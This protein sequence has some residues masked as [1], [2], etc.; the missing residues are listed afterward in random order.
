MS[1]AFSLLLLI[2]AVVIGNLLAA[3]IRLIPAA[4]W[5][6]A[7]GLLFSLL[8]WFHNFEMVPEV[9]LFVIISMLM[10]NE[11]QHTNVRKLVQN[12]G[13]TLSMS[14]WLSLATIVVVGL[15]THLFLPALS[16]PLAFVLGAIITPTDSVAVTSITSDLKVP[17]PVMETLETESLFNDA[18]GL[19]VF[20]LCIAAITTGYFSVTHAVANFIYVFGG[21]ILLGGI[22]G[23][24]LIMIRLWMIRQRLN[25]P[26]IIIPYKLLIPFII[27]VTAEL[28]GVSGI[29]AVVAA[30]IVHGWQQNLLKLSSS[31]LQIT[32]NSAWELVTSILNG[33][34]FV[35]LGISFPEVWHQLQEHSV[36]NLA[37]LVGLGLVLYVVMLVV[38]FLWVRLRF[39]KI[40]HQRKKNRFTDSALIAV[41]GV[42]GTIT[43]AMA[44]S[45]PLTLNHRPFSD[46][47]DLIFV[48]AVVIVLSLLVPTIVL[49]LTLPAKEEPVTLAELD[50]AKSETIN[51]AITLVQQQPTTNT[52]IAVIETLNSQRAEPVRSDPKKVNALMDQTRQ[53]DHD[54]IQQMLADGEIS[55]Q[56]ADTYN[57]MA[58]MMYRR[59]DQSFWQVTKDWWDRLIPFT[60]IHREHRRRKKAYLNQPASARKTDRKEWI[61]NMRRIEAKP[62]AVISDFLTNLPD[63]FNHPEIMA[64]RSFYDQ[65]HRAWNRTRD[66]QS[67]QNQLLTSAFQEEYSYI[68][69]RVQDGGF[70]KALGTKLFDEIANDQMLYIQQSSAMADAQ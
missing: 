33:I 66:E 36:H 29:L 39:V 27:Y 63:A 60:K 57:Q 40:P 11:G 19:V 25:G 69:N 42:H 62:Y 43:L 1:L 53:I 9:F 55:V 18:S 15:I 41:N 68:Q 37:L 45:L 49:K 20:N 4:F 47:T 48:S 8:P 22:L 5:D 44:F 3:K 14:V 24:F 13:A 38:R 50:Q 51:S 12:L 35:L 21:G 16:W 54:T 28:I 46:R 23:W 34:V 32:T 67:A 58:A 59:Q 26:Q 31:R 2:F 7:V 17:A 30:G 64:V 10:F 52:T 56:D 65:R 70:S 61:T 6:I